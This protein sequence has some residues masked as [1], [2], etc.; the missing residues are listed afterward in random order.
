MGKA[1]KDPTADAAVGWLMK[2]NKKERIKKKIFKE[3]I[4]NVARLCGLKVHITFINSE[5]RRK[6]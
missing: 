5:T 6:A 1:Y 2:K 3:A 4:Y